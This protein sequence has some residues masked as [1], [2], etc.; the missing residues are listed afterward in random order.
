MCPEMNWSN[1]EIDHVK[2]ISSFDVTRDEGMREAFNWMN[3]QIRMKQVYQ[4]KAINL[5]SSRIDYNS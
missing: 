5:I 3:T 1:I 4:H 2:P